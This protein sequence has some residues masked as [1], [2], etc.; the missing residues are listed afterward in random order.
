MGDEKLIG[1][2]S[3]FAGRASDPPPAT[4]LACEP[5]NSLEASPFC[6][7]RG[8]PLTDRLER[9]PFD[10][11]CEAVGD[12]ISLAGV[13]REDGVLD[14]FLADDRPGEREDGEAAFPLLVDRRLPSDRWE[15][16][17]RGGK[18]NGKGGE[19]QRR[20]ERRESFCGL[21]VR[22]TIRREAASHDA[23]AI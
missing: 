18:S 14:P 13:R 4:V 1:S 21:K 23:C 9:V 16:M 5:N 3:R 15:D 10:P 8:V 22:T 11:D 17:T 20:A 12:T 7:A 6:D 19:R 2:L